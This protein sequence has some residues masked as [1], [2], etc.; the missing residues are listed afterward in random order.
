MPVRNILFAATAALALSLPAAAHGERYSRAN[1]TTESEHALQKLYRSEPFAET[2]AQQAK[3]ILVF[4]SIVRAGFVFGGSFG[5][6]V[7]FY[8]DQHTQY[9]NSLSGSWG[10]QA[11]IQSYGYALFLMNDRALEYLDKSDGWELGVGPTIVVVNA[12]V[13]KN[14]TTTTL[15]DD[16]YAFTFDQEGLMAGLAIE[17]SKISEI[18]P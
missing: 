12:G 2:I 8:P 1:L 11:G 16:V 13:A 14:L 9:Y 18:D 15:N 5:E 17:G 6:G 10:L 4:P 7:L 3:A